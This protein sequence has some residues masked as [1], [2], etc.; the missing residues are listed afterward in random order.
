MA[1]IQT[2]SVAE[3]IR[4]GWLSN[5]THFLPYEDESE[6]RAF[7]N[8][9]RQQQIVGNAVRVA[10][11]FTRTFVHSFYEPE[12]AIANCYDMRHNNISLAD[13]LIEFE[14]GGDLTNDLEENENEEEVGSGSGRGSRSRGEERCSPDKTILLL[15]IQDFSPNKVTNADGEQ[16]EQLSESAHSQSKSSAIRILGGLLYSIFSQG[17]A[18]SSLLTEA[19]G[20]ADADDLSSL[21]RSIA[22][23][24]NCKFG[25]RSPTRSRVRV[26][27]VTLFLQILE[28][29]SFPLSICRLLSD[30]ID[31]GVP[32]GKAA[33]PF[34]SLSEIMED[35]EEMI[36]R[37]QVFLHDA[38]SSS[39]SPA[40]GHIFCGRKEEIATLM[41]I[42]NKM[43]E[44]ATTAA[45]NANNGGGGSDSGSETVFISGMAGTGKSSLVQSVAHVLSNLGWIVVKARFKRG[46]SYD[47]LGIISAMIDDVVSHVVEMKERGEPGDVAYSE[48]VTESILNTIG[49]DGLPGL[50]PFVP[51]LRKLF[52]DIEHC[53]DDTQM[54]TKWR[55]IYSITNIIES[56]L[57]TDR[58]I[59]IC[60]DDLQW[61]EQPSLQLITEVLINL[62]TSGNAS[63]RCLFVGAYRSDEVDDDH[64]LAIQ[65][66]MIILSQGLNTTE[67]CL[68]SLSKT[69]IVDMLMTELKLPRR[70]VDELADIVRKKTSG[71]ALYVVEL[72][73]S[74]LNESIL[75]YSTQKCQYDWDLNRADFIRT[76][77]KVAEFIYSNLSSL[78]QE[79]QFV[80]QML[81]CFGVQTNVSLLE[82]LENFQTG[83]M[84]SLR[85]FIRRGIIDQ[86]GPILMFTHDLIQQAVYEGMDLDARQSLHLRL[87][88]YLGDMGMKDISTVTGRSKQAFFAGNLAIVD[89]VTL[90]CDQINRA[91]VDAVDDQS[92]K[93][94]FSKW[95][96]SSGKKMANESN[97]PAAL[98][99]FENGI[100]FLGE[101]SWQKDHKLCSSL[102]HDAVSAAFRVGQFDTVSELATEILEQE[103]PY[104]D[105]IEIQGFVLRSLLSEYK[106]EEWWS[107]GLHILGRLKI[108]IDT[109]ATDEMVRCR[110]A[111][112]DFAASR[113]TVDDIVSLCNKANGGAS[114]NV[115]KIMII[116]G[117]DS[118]IYSPNMS[119]VL[120]CVS[121]IYSLGHG[122]P[123]MSSASFATYGLWKI[124]ENSDYD[125]GKRWADFSR[126]VIKHHVGTEK[127]ISYE[128]FL[129]LITLN[130]HIDIWFS[131]WREIV[132]KL[133]DISNEALK[134]GE[135]DVAIWS[136]SEGWQLGLH[137]GE[138]LSLISDSS[139]AHLKWMQKY[140][141]RDTFPKMTAMDCI[142]LMELTGKSQ[143]YFS[144]IGGSI[145]SVD[146]WVAE[147]KLIGDSFLLTY[148]HE[149]N[150]MRSYWKG[151]YVAAEEHFHN[152]S[153]L[154][155]SHT[156][157]F[158]HT[159]SH[160]I[161]LVVFFGCLVSFQL[162]REL[163]GDD[164]LKEGTKMLERMERWY[165]V[166]PH[167]FENKWHLL[168]AEHLASIGKDCDAEASY[169]QAINASRDHGYIHDLGLAYE[170]LG[171][172][173]S[174]NG[175]NAHCTHCL[176]K[177]HL[178]YTQWG[179]T[180]VAERLVEQ[181]LDLKSTLGADLHMEIN[182]NEAG[183]GL[184]ARTIGMEVM[185]S[186]DVALYAQSP[187]ETL[188]D[189]E[190][191]DKARISLGVQH[192]QGVVFVLE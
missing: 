83:I 96:L 139:L 6:R 130:A 151:D 106:F 75:T 29:N 122:V 183:T 46:R 31:T 169:I 39:P 88:I 73:N 120:N 140:K 152:A 79:S 82:V 170:L 168:K 26:T 165:H 4:T 179:A 36:S 97:F 1:P 27:E 136:R 119:A 154:L 87:G 84:P 99:Y 86:A 90:A 146:D 66:S 149:V 21:G 94:I 70:M 17:E 121:I 129:A 45:S 172:F 144:V 40:F 44:S 30:T 13:F 69:D 48:R 171:R 58:F 22:S 68:S 188:L 98:Y 54:H 64:P 65:K 41:G 150:L 19:S 35:L 51:S 63:G 60:C 32:D 42:V 2:I 166:S 77:D 101:N 92:Q 93:L 126:A 117:F 7:S 80:L 100:S 95:N 47:S 57:D 185:L 125:A 184:S 78:T 108:G 81:S 181:G 147:A 105:T 128:S 91:G 143:N 62:G 145:T 38:P 190:S 116:F 104:E 141:T 43:E 110:M 158:V 71:H 160:T 55:L 161:V 15:G 9:T 164:R 133:M 173:Y 5:G 3:F 52:G 153:L 14:P 89:L 186:A 163:G 109:S 114:Y 107:K 111:H 177:A 180:A 123:L 11:L 28:Q 118:P 148:I 74:L 112:T 159:I 127:G 162:Y 132:P 192:S 50:A 187:H 56:V 138:N 61:A 176:K 167:L 85:E 23:V 20:G 124:K 16:W 156:I 24:G 49:A 142:L 174:A 72:L 103:Q 135:I 76:G 178:F 102:Y 131:P 113:Y 67:I 34:E 134:F 182:P 18:I 10:L 59:M 157:A 33:K 12:S 37:P 25:Q 53:D 175:S 137:G 8:T 191:S 115:L 189:F 155:V